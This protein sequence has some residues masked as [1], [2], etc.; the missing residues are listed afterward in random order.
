MEEEK[1]N[2]QVEYNLSM[3][4]II[5]VGRLI[6]EADSLFLRGDY[7]GAFFRFKCIFIHIRNRLTEEQIKKSKKIEKKFF[8][9]RDTNKKIPEYK[10]KGYY[11]EK[12]STLIN[13]FLKDIGMD[14]REKEEEPD[15]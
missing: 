1:G 14:M 2:E 3:M 7:S 11:Y 4:K 5:Q 9:K 15:F 8:E 10:Y 6:Q 12:Y 13:S